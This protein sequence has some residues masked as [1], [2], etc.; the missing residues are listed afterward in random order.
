MHRVVPRADP[1][2]A[3]PAPGRAAI[4]R[5]VI[6]LELMILRVWARERTGRMAQL[7]C[8]VSST[9]IRSLRAWVDI[10]RHAH[11]SKSGCGVV[12]RFTRFA[13]SAC[14]SKGDLLSP[15]AEVNTLE[16]FW[17]RAL[18]TIAR[19]AELGSHGLNSEMVA[20]AAREHA[21]MVRR[22]GQFKS[23]F[24][25]A[26]S[27]RKARGCGV[28]AGL[29]TDRCAVSPGHSRARNRTGTPE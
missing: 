14:S 29:G 5:D 8:L 17:T 10:A 9:G 2:R 28:V 3:V 19:L 20:E 24:R 7:W 16:R 4:P 22:I 27:A 26:L 23:K 1:R 13:R 21:R 18:R 15:D 6:L 12:A 25:D 11:F